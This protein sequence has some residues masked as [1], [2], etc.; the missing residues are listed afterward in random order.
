MT[1]SAFDFP[2]GDGLVIRGWDE[3]VSEAARRH[4]WLVRAAWTISPTR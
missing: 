4:Q 1:T 3:G 2:L